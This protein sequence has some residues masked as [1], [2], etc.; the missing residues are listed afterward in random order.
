MCHGRPGEG[1]RKLEFMERSEDLKELG[2]H[3]EFERTLFWE[4]G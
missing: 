2:S 1:S 4:S 3:L